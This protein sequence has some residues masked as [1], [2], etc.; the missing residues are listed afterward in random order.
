MA[1]KYA[2]AGGEHELILREPCYQEYKTTVKI[3]SG[4]T[5]TVSQSLQPLAPAKPPFGTKACN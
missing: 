2:V 3:E 4:M 5:A 1:R